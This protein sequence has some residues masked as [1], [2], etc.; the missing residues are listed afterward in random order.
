MN[1]T[2]KFCQ[3]GSYL[4]H[5]DADRF[6]QSAFSQHITVQLS[7]LKGGSVAFE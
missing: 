2:I 6:M 7:E 4:A 5:P 1:T 3:D